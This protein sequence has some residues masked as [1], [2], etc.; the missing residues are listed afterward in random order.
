MRT[1][2]PT[3]TI[4]PAICVVIA[5]ERTK[6]EIDRYRLAQDDGT[7]A[8]FR[9]WMHDN[10]IYP[11]PE[12]SSGPGFWSGYFNAEDEATLREFFGR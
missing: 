9:Q 4:E 2:T 8:R 11:R 5:V 1:A 7:I 3:V 6:S 10:D 12:I